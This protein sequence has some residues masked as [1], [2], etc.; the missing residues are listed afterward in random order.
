MKIWKD[1]LFLDDINNFS[2]NT[3]VSL[4]GIEYTEYGDDYL[5]AV[6]PVSEK[7]SQP[8][9]FLH[10]GASCT[11]AETVASAAGNLCCSPDCFCKGYEVNCVHVHSAVVGETVEAVARPFHL[12]RRMQ[13][14]QVDISNKKTEKL[15]C[16]A[17]VSLVVCSKA[18]LEIVRR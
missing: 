9:G 7:T 3:M 17:T 12:G 4:L 8:M 5:K 1:D 13:T 10:G 16:R 14:W 11:L 2:S 15:I 6:M 18:E